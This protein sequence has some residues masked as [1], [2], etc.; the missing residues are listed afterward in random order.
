MTV[1]LL[2]SDR[3]ALLFGASDDLVAAVVRLVERQFD[4]DIVRPPWF[5]GRADQIG[6][7]ALWST[8]MLLSGWVFRKRYRVATIASGVALVSVGFELAQPAL[9]SYRAIEQTDLVAN[10][11]GVM[12]GAAAIWLLIRAERKW[13]PLLA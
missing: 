8:G 7:A 2:W 9:S 1:V 12:I 5:P 10:L 13:L 4:V 3:A 11:T 6:H